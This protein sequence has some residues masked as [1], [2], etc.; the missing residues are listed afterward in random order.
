VTVLAKLVVPTNCLV[1]VRLAG[2]KVSGDAAP[3]EPVPESA[4]CC[5]LKAAL[6]ENCTQLVYPP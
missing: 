1:N 4:T 2:E 3:P 6:W 5:G